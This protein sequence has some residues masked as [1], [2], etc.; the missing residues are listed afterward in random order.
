M[1]RKLENALKERFLFWL[2]H[3]EKKSSLVFE[4]LE[5]DVKEDFEKRMKPFN[6]VIF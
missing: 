6:M 1:L 2:H 5:A 3:D 4:K